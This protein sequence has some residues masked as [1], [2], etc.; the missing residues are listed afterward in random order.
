[1]QILWEQTRILC[2]DDGYVLGIEGGSIPFIY[3]ISIMIIIT[4]ALRK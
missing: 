3:R 2:D 4:H 1:M